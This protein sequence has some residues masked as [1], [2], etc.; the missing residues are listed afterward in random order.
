MHNSLKNR[1]YDLAI[2]AIAQFMIVLDV[3]IVN[4]ALPSMQKDLGLSIS[5]LQGIVT[6]YTLAFGGF[7]LLGGRAADLYG[8]KRIFLAG[9]ACFTL[10]SLTIGIADNATLMVPLRAL[11]GLSAAFMSPA[12]L[13]LVLSIFTDQKERS[14]A[15]S[16]WGAVSAGGATAGLLIGGILTQYINWRWNFFVN[17]PVGITVFLLAWNMLP[18]HTVE[19]KSKTL[20]LPGA[21]LATSGMML[22]VYALSHGN[23]WGWLSSTSL[24]CIILS[25]LLLVGFVYN[26]SVVAHPLMP[27][28]FFRIGNIAGALGMQ[29]PVTASMF[30]MFF[31][32]SIYVQNVLHYSPLE[33][34]FAFLPVSII[35]G[36]VATQAPRAIRTFGYR[37]LLVVAPFFLATGLVLFTYTTVDSTYWNILP[38]LL[39]MPIGLGLAFVSITIAATTGVPPQE[40]GLAS[41]LLTTAQ[42]IGGSLGLA[43]LSGIAAATTSTSLGQGY[44]LAV[45]QVNGFHG[46]YYAGVICAM[47]A[48]I[49][50]YTF[51]RP[52]T[53]AEDSSESLPVHI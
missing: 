51:I 31:F 25:I 21:V 10:V 30:A 28:S 53:V 18:S 29:L 24:G 7:L 13:S 26:E 5:D 46:A 44:P 49:I 50:A 38:G 48:A 14:R 8:R 47:V 3:S 17:V 1:W 36:I 4:V 6:A 34:G 23:T 35:I 2:L 16:L 43:V 41:G 15:L 33:T 11:Q 42:Q 9:I 20:D 40:S 22:L 37:T 39:I 27:L 52:I 32:L 45:A 19:E 12:A